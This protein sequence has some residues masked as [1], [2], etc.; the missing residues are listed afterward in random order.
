MKSP[1]QNKRALKRS[2]GEESPPPTQDPT[3]NPVASPDQSSVKDDEIQEVT[4]VLLLNGKNRSDYFLEALR[5]GMV[6]I[7]HT[8]AESRLERT[9]D[10]PIEARRFVEDLKVAMRTP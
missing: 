3:Q 7:E 8:S 5:L 2:S 9:F 10:S 4:V 1:K 6:L